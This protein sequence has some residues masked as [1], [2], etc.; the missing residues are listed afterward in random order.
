[1]TPV[2]PNELL[3]ACSDVPSMEQLEPSV[4]EVV[5]QLRQLRRTKQEALKQ[6]SIRIEFQ[7]SGCL[8]YV[9]C[10]SVAFTTNEE[11][12][13]SLKEFI[14]DPINVGKFWENKFNND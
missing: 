12:M 14:D 6:H 4:S 8:V 7:S 13:K 11:A 3:D 5:E 1:M 9:G 10:K 2:N